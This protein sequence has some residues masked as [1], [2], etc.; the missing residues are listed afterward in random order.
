MLFEFG[1][2]PAAEVLESFRP[3]IESR[4]FDDPSEA[5]PQVRSVVAIASYDELPP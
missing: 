5:S 4:S 3:G 1:L 2:A